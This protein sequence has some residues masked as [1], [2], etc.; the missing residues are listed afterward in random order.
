M[1]LDI[2]VAGGDWSRIPRLKHLARRAAN[3]ALKEAGRRPG[4]LSAS[5]LFTDDA[6]MKELN[7]RF[8]AKPQPTNVLSFPAAGP[9]AP[10]GEPDHLG[11]VVLS[12]GVI[13]AE[14]E[15]QDKP[16]PAHLSHLIVHGMLHLLGYDHRSPDEADLM[17]ALEARV[18]A[19]LGYPD[20]YCAS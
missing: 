19:R 2:A 10:A 15:R 13:S 8:R 11:D 5:L 14:A 7:G 3:A 18:L 4:N 12:W 20:P 1:K 16:L 9:A 17:E 6:E